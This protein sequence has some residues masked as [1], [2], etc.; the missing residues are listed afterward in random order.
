MV[1]PPWNPPQAVFLVQGATIVECR[2][3]GW[4]PSEAPPPSKFAV[5][6][7]TVACPVGIYRYGTCICGALLLW[8][9]FLCLLNRGGQR[10]DFASLRPGSAARRHGDHPGG[11]S[12]SSRV[13]VVFIEL[14]DTRHLS[15]AWSAATLCVC[16]IIL[17]VD[18]VWLQAPATTVGWV[19]AQAYAADDRI[20]GFCV[21]WATVQGGR[22]TRA[23]C[24][25][26]S[27]E[28]YIFGV[29]WTVRCCGH[30]V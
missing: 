3:I 21:P 22:V 20:H 29:H 11:E 2:L 5:D 10:A 4:C 8:C 14:C 30:H 15:G 7:E 25:D 19:G 6:T 26:Y 9:F 17:I 27:R 24:V 18:A 23:R 1:A 16:A 28:A 13:A 12:W